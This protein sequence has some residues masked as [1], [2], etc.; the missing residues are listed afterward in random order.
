MSD[1]IT[2]EGVTMQYSGAGRYQ[3]G[4]KQALLDGMAFWRKI[5]RP[6][7]PK[8]L[9]HVTFSIKA[10]ESTAIIGRNGS[11]KSTTLALIA[12]VLHPT[13]GKVLVSGR[14]APLLELGA[15]FHPDLTGRENAELNAVLLGMTRAEA[16]KRLPAI[17]DFAQIGPAIDSPIRTYSSGMMARLGFAVAVHVDAEILLIDEILAVGDVLFQRQCVERIRFLQAQGMAIIY[18]GHGLE[19]VKDICSKALFM[20][21]GICLGH[22]PIA[23]ISDAYEKSF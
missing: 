11:G 9:D 20:Q 22:G 12:G 6:P 14:V 19:L 5:E 21:A 13:S 18:V 10:G 8:A 16:Q 15:G 2:F 23:E 17:L 4:S 3:H 1:L 7:I